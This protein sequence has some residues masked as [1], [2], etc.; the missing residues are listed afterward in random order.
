MKIETISQQIKLQEKA[1]V[2]KVLTAQGNVTLF[3]LAQGA[4]ISPHT[5]DQEAEV[6]V[7]SVLGRSCCCMA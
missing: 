6:L 7:L 2:S 4:G 3:A 5:S 1:I